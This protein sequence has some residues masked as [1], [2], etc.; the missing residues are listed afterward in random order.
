MSYTRIQF[1]N[2]KASLC[3]VARLSYHCTYKTENFG[4]IAQLVNKVMLL[5]SHAIGC[6]YNKI[7]FHKFSMQLSIKLVLLCVTATDEGAAD[8]NVVL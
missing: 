2:F 8:K 1:F 6:V 5:Q 4:L 7:P 3:L